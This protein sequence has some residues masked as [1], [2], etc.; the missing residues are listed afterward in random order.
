MWQRVWQRL[1]DPV[2]Y[3]KHG[4]GLVRW[5]APP[6]A[7]RPLS[8]EALFG[9]GMPG[10]RP[11]LV[12]IAHPDDELFCAALIDRLREAAVPVHLACLTRGEGGPVGEGGTREG[13]G[14]VREAELRASAGALGVAEVRFLDCVDPVGWSHRVFAPAVSVAELS[15]RIEAE[16]SRIDPAAVITHG[17]GGEYWHPAHLLCHAAVFRAL[18]GKAGPRLPVLTM[19][20]WQPGH[21]LPGW[22]NRDDPADLVIDAGP[23]RARRLAALRCHRSQ[24]GFFTRLGGGRPEGF[25][26]RTPTEGYRVHLP[27]GWTAVHREAASASPA[28]CGR[29]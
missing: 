15:R 21:P 22:L 13:L 12:V 27:P 16:R 6:R 11:V 20:A 18:G 25:L 7:P 17:S 3:R 26:D 24:A 10:G 29:G 19:Q 2:T 1:T 8:F 28:G 9:G 14:R 23:H 4:R 5:V